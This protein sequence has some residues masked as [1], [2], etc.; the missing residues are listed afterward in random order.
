MKWPNGATKISM[1]TYNLKCMVIKVHQNVNFIILLA[2]WTYWRQKEHQAKMIH[3]KLELNSIFQ[4]SHEKI[5]KLQL[6]EEKNLLSRLRWWRRPMPTKWKWFLTN[7]M[8][9]KL[10][11]LRK[12]L[13]SR[14]HLRVPI[15]IIAISLNS[16][17]ETLKPQKSKKVVL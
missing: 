2:N 1:K 10:Q 7:K 16:R 4:K 9:K 17:W 6:R 11:H 13:I 3:S 5:L 15:Q 8:L 14:Q 12:F